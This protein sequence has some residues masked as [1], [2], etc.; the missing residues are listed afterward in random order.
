MIGEKDRDG[1]QT[2]LRL[3]LLNSSLKCFVWVGRCSAQQT[4]STDPSS[5]F[6]KVPLM[7]RGNE[8]F[9]CARTNALVKTAP[10]P[11][12][13][14]RSGFKSICSRLR[15]EAPMGVCCAHLVAVV[16][17]LLEPHPLVQHPHDDEPLLVAG[18]QLA[19]VLVPA[20]HQ[21]R[22]AVPLQRLV[23]AQVARSAAR[24]CRTLAVLARHAVQLQHLQ[25][26]VVIEVLQS[27]ILW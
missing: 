17:H 16:D 21:H 9:G 13:S 27:P 23:H 2:L 3:Q 5:Y 6:E 7:D 11:C 1:T 19:V 25:G 8:T 4:V 15:T 26:I 24:G 22:P 12:A 20:R 14:G 18:G 10:T